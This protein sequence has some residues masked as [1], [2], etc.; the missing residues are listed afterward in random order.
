[1]GR[2]DR[3]LGVRVLSGAVGRRPRFLFP[4]DPHAT[5]RPKRHGRAA[6]N[7]LTPACHRV[8]ARCTAVWCREHLGRTCGEELAVA[9]STPR[10]RPTERPQTI[11]AWLGPSHLPRGFLERSIG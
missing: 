7:W 5:T 2:Q 11:T 8:L 9:G 6:R 4:A 10:V 1:M 3:L